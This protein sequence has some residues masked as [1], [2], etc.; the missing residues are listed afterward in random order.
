MRRARP[1]F[2]R[3]ATRELWL[4]AGLLVLVSVA[5]A[6]GWLM[7]RMRMLRPIRETTLHSPNS[8]PGAAISAARSGISGNRD[9]SPLA[10]A[11]NAFLARV[12]ELIFDVRR[13]SVSIA[14]ESAKM[15]RRIQDTSGSASEQGNLTAVI[16]TSSGEVHGAIGSVSQNA[17]AISTATAAHVDAAQVSYSELLDVT[18]RIQQIGQRLNQF[19]TT[20]RELSRHSAGIRDIGLS[21]NDISDQTNLLALNAAIEAARAGEARPRLRC[22]GRRGA[23]AGRKGEVRDRHESRRTPSTSW[24]S[25]RARR[26]R[27]KRSTPMRSTREKS[28][29][30][31][32]GTSSVWC[33]A[34]R[35]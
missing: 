20:V 4:T 24:G 31:R 22:G 29:R 2:K 10:E 9:F 7:A 13:S 34:S 27:R 33:K 14:I 18:E 11:L 15:G 35:S 16:F 30:S 23:E 6:A 3:L 26:A 25:C 1:T 32:P 28:C 21:I 5:F 12:R 17:G 19:N 8:V